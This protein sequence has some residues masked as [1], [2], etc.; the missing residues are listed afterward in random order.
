MN[1][2]N[3]ARAALGVLV[4]EDGAAIA[5]GPVVAMPMSV[6][7]RS[8][9]FQLAFP[10]D[11]RTPLRVVLGDPIHGSCESRFPLLR[12]SSSGVAPAPIQIGALQAIRFWGYGCANYRPKML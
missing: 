12:T 1:W 3:S 2:P 4:A 10:A 6:P 5:G 8:G 9:P 11:A 7:P